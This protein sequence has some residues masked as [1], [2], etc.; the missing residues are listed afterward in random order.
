[1]SQL[2]SLPNSDVRILGRADVREDAI[3][4]DW[5]NSGVFFRFRGTKAALRFDVPAM[6]QR[7]FM[8]VWI[9]GRWSRVCL[10]EGSTVVEAIAAEDGDHKVYCT[11][12]N[13]VLDG[14][15]VVLRDIELEGAAPALLN[16]PVLPDRRMMFIGDSITC[17]FGLLTEGTGNGFKTDEQDGAH[18][19]AALTAA[20]FQ[21][22]A[23]FIC[24]SGRGIVRNCD[25]FQAPLIPEFFEQTTVSNPT[26]WDHT[27]YSPDIVVVNAGTNDADGE[28]H[29]T[30]EKFQAGVRAFI[31][32]LRELY[33]QAKILWTYGMMNGFMHDALKETVNALADPAVQYLPLGSVYDHEN[34][35]GACCHPNQRAHRRCA[36][37]MIDAVAAITG[38][39]K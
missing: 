22:Q 4:F 24:I 10:E 16:A 33:P 29:T 32:R 15:P 25:D 39:A 9:D 11:R 8:Q 6:N 28:N 34:E 13:E 31:G 14:V 27:A 7:L 26:P 18:T 3:A 38:W 5:T 36:G 20:H 35:L 2:V 19:Y 21:A 30:P 17:G 12:I 1:M 37:V 23:H